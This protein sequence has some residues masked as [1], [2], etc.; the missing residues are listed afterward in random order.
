[1][2]LQDLC[3]KYTA[4]YQELEKLKES[5]QNKE[6]TLKSMT[7]KINLFKELQEEAKKAE[8][9]R[10]RLEGE[11]KEL[12]SVASRAETLAAR[13]NNKINTT[14]EV[15]EIRTQIER[16]IRKVDIDERNVSQKA[17]DIS[18]LHNEIEAIQI[19]LN[20]NPDSDS[21]KLSDVFGELRIMR[22]NITRNRVQ[23]I[24]LYCQM[25]EMLGETEAKFHAA[26]LKLMAEEQISS[27]IQSSNLSGEVEKVAGVIKS[28][29]QIKYDKAEEIDGSI[30]TLISIEKEIERSI[31]SLYENE[32]TKNKLVSER[33][34][35]AGIKSGLE[36]DL[37]NLLSRE[38]QLRDEYNLVQKKSINEEIADLNTKADSLME[39]N[40][41]KQRDNSE[42]RSKKRMMG[43]NATPTEKHAARIEDQTARLED[44]LREMEK[45]IA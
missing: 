43:S 28:I 1:M 31:D 18:S 44:K 5:Y 39:E 35:V 27:A 38:L 20:D 33:S 32:S 24:K 36:G 7:D 19:K 29:P 13:E 26:E 41:K 17:L 30:N 4:K 11:I 15:K 16:M 34:K 12:E 6:K 42:M 37:N 14:P 22:S 40:Q 10:P 45:E 23:N 2:S 3:A 25:M 21:D 9:D 8:S